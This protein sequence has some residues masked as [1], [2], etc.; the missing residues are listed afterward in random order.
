M[1]TRK[2]YIWKKTHNNLNMLQDTS[3]YRLPRGYSTISY[4]KQKWIPLDPLKAH[5]AHWD[6]CLSNR[7]P[8]SDK[9]TE[10]P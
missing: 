7:G 6:F 9:Y 5:I 3:T 4:H 2:E 10:D 1:K 8:Q